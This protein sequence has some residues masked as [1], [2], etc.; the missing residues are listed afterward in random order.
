MVMYGYVGLCRGAKG[1]RSGESARLPPVWPEFNSRRRRHMWVEFAVG[2]LLCSE[3]F[4]SGY[5]GFPLSSKT[6]ISKFQFDQESG[7]RRNT[8]WMCY[9]Q[10]II[11]L[12][13]YLFIYVG[14][15]M[16]SYVGLCRA[17]YGC[18]WTCR[19]MYGYLRLCM[20]MYGY[21]EQC[22]ALYG[23]VGLCRAM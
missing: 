14:Q 18:V 7:R 16:A 3:R 8:L 12:F 10:I 4:F 20:A 6:N 23:Y 13:I 11:Y 15:C 21:V 17:M 22:R 9:L 5:S 19:S 1:W 2:S